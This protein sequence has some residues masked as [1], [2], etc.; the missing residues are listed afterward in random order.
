MCFGL[1]NEAEGEGG[2]EYGAGDEGAEEAAGVLAVVV[3]EQCAEGSGD[4][5]ISF[6]RSISRNVL[7]VKALRFFALAV[8]L[9]RINAFS[10]AMSK[11]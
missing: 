3:G 7:C 6:N 5:S 11:T 8:S 2:S 9:C 1:W 10:T 4:S